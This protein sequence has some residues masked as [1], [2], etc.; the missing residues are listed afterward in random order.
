MRAPGA[1]H[2]GSPRRVSKATNRP[3]SLSP[4]LSLAA[5]GQLE[6]PAASSLTARRSSL[7]SRDSKS[8]VA[9]AT[10]GETEQLSATGLNT[11]T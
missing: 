7:Q 11:M 10:T 3:I 9:R 8:V 2:C 6:R 5:N 1:A 4:T